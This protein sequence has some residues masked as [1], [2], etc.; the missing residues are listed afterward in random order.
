MHDPRSQIFPTSTRVL[1]ESRVIPVTRKWETTSGRV[2]VFPSSVPTTVLPI[3][4]TDGSTDRPTE[5]QVCQTSTTRTVP[6]GSR[7]HDSFCV[8]SFVGS[9]LLSFLRFSTSDERPPQHLNTQHWN[10]QPSSEYFTTYRSLIVEFLQAPFCSLYSAFDHTLTLENTHTHTVPCSFG[11]GVCPTLRGL[12]CPRL[13]YPFRNTDEA[14]SPPTPCHSSGTLR[15]GD[16]FVG[17]DEESSLRWSRLGRGVAYGP[18][19]TPLFRAFRRTL[20]R[21]QG[22]WPFADPHVAIGR[23]FDR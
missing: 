14:F 15:C 3:R 20:H 4:A 23:I 1:I 13:R 21:T 2:I 6:Y 16:E 8:P 12:Q 18:T 19:T 17:D 10:L 11:R 5:P 9:C 7:P 22:Q